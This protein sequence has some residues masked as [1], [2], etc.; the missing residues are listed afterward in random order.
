LF[1]LASLGLGLVISSTARQQFVA[2]QASILAGFLPAFFL[3][4]LI[5]DL[6]STPLA[7]RIISH[8]VP[9]RWFVEASQTLFLAGDVGSVLW[10]DAGVLAL[11]A[12][13]LL[14]IARRKTPIRLAE[15]RS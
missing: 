12:A 10:R 7:I 8:V 3:S 13:L 5:F 15:D 1:L 14:T 11:M 4:G 2:A 9:A 6:G